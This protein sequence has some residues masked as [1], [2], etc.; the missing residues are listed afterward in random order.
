M[1][2]FELDGVLADIK[3]TRHFRFRLYT[4]MTKIL[5]ILPL[6][7]ILCGCD[8]GRIIQ[9]SDGHTYT[10]QPDHYEHDPQCGKCQEMKK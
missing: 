3:H 10:W 6:A 2:I 1:I 5:Y 8:G 7:L 9:K 4:T